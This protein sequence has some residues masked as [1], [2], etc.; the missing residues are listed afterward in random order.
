MSGKN[1]RIEDLSMESS[2][3]EIKQKL[4][5][6]EGVA[7]HNQGIYLLKGQKVEQVELVPKG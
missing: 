7:V 2:V 6:L 5:E 3:K 4:R 1:V